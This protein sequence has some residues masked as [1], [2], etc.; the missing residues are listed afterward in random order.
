MPAWDFDVRG[1]SRTGHAA[2]GFEIGTA[3][4]IFTGAEVPS[5]ADAVV[6][7]EDVER[8]GNVARFGSRPKPGQHIRAAGEDLRRGAVALE[9]GTRLGA[10]QL[11]LAGAADVAEVCVARRPRVAILCTGDELRAPGTSPRPGIPESNGVV[12]ATLA[13]SAGAICRAPEVM[14]D[15][16]QLT[17]DRIRTHRFV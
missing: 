9:A 13:T 14:V 1:E 17:R 11:G 2:R 16:L 3:C 12:I 5:G 8:L 15:D 6:M 10:Y 4:R 7:Q